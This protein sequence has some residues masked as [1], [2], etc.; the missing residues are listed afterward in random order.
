[1]N[2][3]L[4]SISVALVFAIS[5]VGQT[6]CPADKVCISREAAIKALQDSDTVKAQA[7]EIRVKDSAI[8]ALKA[9][10]AK[11]QIELAKTTG[12][13]TGSQQ[14]VVRLT[15]ITDILLKNSKKRC[16]PLSICF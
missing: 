14:M 8:D 15:A 7:A 16:A 3:L 6:D 4:L 12:E 13:L 9:E 10:V 5:A 1:M 11:M 2:K